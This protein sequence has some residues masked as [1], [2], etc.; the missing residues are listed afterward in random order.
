MFFFFFFFRNVCFSDPVPNIYVLS[1]LLNLIGCHRNQKAKFANI[2]KKQL[3]R[4][5]MGDK[6]ETLQNCS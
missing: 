4:S 3:L 6:A 2:L 1:K 5:Y